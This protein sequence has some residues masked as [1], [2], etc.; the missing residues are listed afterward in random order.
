MYLGTYKQFEYY[1]GYSIRS[2]M[3]NRL[4]HYITITL[5]IFIMIVTYGI[6]QAGFPKVHQIHVSEF[7]PLEVIT[8]IVVLY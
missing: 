1:S 4:N 7:G 3:N 2:L 6:I 5:I 8:L